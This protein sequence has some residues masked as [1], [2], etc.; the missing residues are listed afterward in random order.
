MAEPS[1]SIAAT[2]ASLGTARRLEAAGLRE[3]HVAERRPCLDGVEAAL[4]MA[5]AE[6]RP[7]PVKLVG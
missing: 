4:A 6:H 7:A 3:Q 5:W 1:V 2:P